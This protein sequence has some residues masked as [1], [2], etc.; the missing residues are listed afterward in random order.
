MGG[1]EETLVCTTGCRLIPV[2]ETGPAK[3]DQFLEGK[4]M[5]TERNLSLILDM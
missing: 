3:E 1:K 5:K 2:M 4:R